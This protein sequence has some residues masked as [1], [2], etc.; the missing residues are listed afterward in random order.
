[1]GTRGGQPVPR[2]VVRPQR[3]PGRAGSSHWPAR[4]FQPLPSPRDTVGPTWAP[5]PQM[6]RSPKKMR[7]S[8]GTGAPWRR[9][10][11]KGGSGRAE[12]WGQRHTEAS[13]AA[14]RVRRELGEKGR[15]ARGLLP[16]SLRGAA[17]RLRP[18]G[19]AGQG[20]RVRDPVRRCLGAGRRHLQPESTSREGCI[21]AC[22]QGAPWDSGGSPSPHTRGK[23]VRGSH[24][25]V[26]SGDTEGRGWGRGVG[27][28]P[29]G[30]GSAGPA[31]AVWAPAWM[32]PLV[33]EVSAQS[34]G[35]RYPALERGASQQPRCPPQRPPSPRGGG[36]L[37]Q[38]SPGSP[39]TGA[40]TKAASP[41][42]R[43]GRGRQAGAGQGG[44]ARPTGSGPPR[45]PAVCGSPR[46]EPLSAPWT[47]PPA[48]GRETGVGPA[49]RAQGPQGTPQCVG[50][51]HQG[52]LGSLLRPHPSSTLGLR[53]RPGARWSRGSRQ[54]GH[55][56][57]Q[58]APPPTGGQR[59]QAQIGAAGRWGTVWGRPHPAH[60]AAAPP[61]PSCSGSGA[62]R[63][64]AL[65]R[66]P[67]HSAQVEA[68][69][70]RGSEER[71]AGA[72]FRG[73]ASRLTPGSPG[74]ARE[75]PRP[76][77]PTANALGPA[78]LGPPA[79]RT[80]RG[81]PRTQA[82][83]GGSRLR[84]HRRAP[85]AFCPRPPTPFPSARP[86]RQSVMG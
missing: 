42:L 59:A 75:T 45:G 56:S 35:P 30:S 85:E 73:V 37:P 1:M 60:T 17:C 55:L 5:Q 43:A 14:T 82:A 49:H 76:S 34:Q 28:P 74:P 71:R 6:E 44:G 22:V 39:P 79:R 69:L 4:E 78:R 13:T 83:R 86:R 38:P 48:R 7:P 12:F 53:P 84:R 62:P 16:H 10:R 19:R 54:G 27:R 77:R 11:W 81:V 20:S 3:H 58:D 31:G 21:A 61:R 70:A 67:V 47:G 29:L 52:A 9:P 25:H 24:Q 36:S 64:R 80:P 33:P 23:R 68:D 51:Q 66:L 65:V 72:E 18:L 57:A 32:G 63:A 41:P 46:Q 15:G 8:P 26:R 2:G 50:R 40:G